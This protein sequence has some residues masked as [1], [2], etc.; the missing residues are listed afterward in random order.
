MCTFF[1][2]LC[3]LHDRACREPSNVECA[4]KSH[5]AA[6]D[7]FLIVFANVFIYKYAEKKMD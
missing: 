6:V 4:Q 5:I 1:I 7:S 3:K 2:S